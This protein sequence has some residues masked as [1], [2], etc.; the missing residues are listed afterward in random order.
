MWIIK[1]NVTL[2]GDTGSYLHQDYP[3][4]TLEPSSPIINS[5]TTCVSKDYFVKLLFS[6][7]HSAYD[8][9]RDYKSGKGIHIKKTSANKKLT[10]NR[11]QTTLTPVL[12]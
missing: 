4:S 9:Y 10:R 8:V 11:P 2:L 3:N 12:F 5:Y 7:S 1:P 6:T